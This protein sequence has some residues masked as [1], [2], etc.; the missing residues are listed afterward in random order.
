MAGLK[1]RTFVWVISNRLA[2]CER[3]GGHGFQHR[4]VRREEEIAWLREQG[5]NTVVSLLAG[6][7]NL[8]N[9]Q[10][11]G[12]RTYH[13]PLVGEFE[14]ED[15]REVFVILQQALSDPSAVVLVHRDLIDDVV[16]GVLAGYL[17]YS[18]LVDDPIVAVAAIQQIIGRPVG[19][20]GR[21]LVP[22]R[23][24]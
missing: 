12:F 19:P 14:P 1:P 8:A 11:A 18:R 23:T 13:R 20:E 22:T 5:V 4:R 2:V 24:S 21:R 16:A 6:N 7:Q 9:Y 15:V 10:A 3:I 17:M